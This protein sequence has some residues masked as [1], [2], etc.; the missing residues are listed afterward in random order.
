MTGHR[1]RIDWMTWTLKIALVGLAAGT[2]SAGAQPRPM[3]PH[4]RAGDGAS[5]GA[6]DSPARQPLLPG[7]SAL[8][9]STRVR[10]DSDDALALEEIALKPRKADIAVSRVTLVWTPWRVTAQGLFEPAG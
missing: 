4:S 1:R 2:A 3:V 8:P 6:A 9:G 10:Y 7:F 5:D